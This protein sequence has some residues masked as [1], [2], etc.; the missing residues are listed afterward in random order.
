MCH[1]VFIYS[2]GFVPVETLKLVKI[3]GRYDVIEL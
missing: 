1:R 3:K 2:I